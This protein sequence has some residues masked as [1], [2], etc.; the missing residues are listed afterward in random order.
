MAIG[1]FDLTGVYSM[2]AL[3]CENTIIAA[4]TRGRIWHTAAIQCVKTQ[5]N[6]D[7]MYTIA[8][9]CYRAADVAVKLLATNHTD[10]T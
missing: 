10:E 6:E 7:P 8:M 2:K 5:N 4:V 1:H 3:P 9:A